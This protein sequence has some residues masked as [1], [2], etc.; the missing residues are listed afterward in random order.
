MLYLYD[1]L[2]HGNLSESTM[3]EKHVILVLR[4]I[5]FALVKIIDSR[6]QHE[7]PARDLFLQFLKHVVS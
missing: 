5:I 2:I 6:R 3:K 1:D 7:A 4:D